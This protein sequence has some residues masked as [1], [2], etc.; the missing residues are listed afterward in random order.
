MAT[1]DGEEGRLGALR[2]GTMEF[3]Q[4]GNRFT[5]SGANSDNVYN[6]ACMASKSVWKRWYQPCE[7]SPWTTN[8][9]STLLLS[10]AS[11]VMSMPKPRSAGVSCPV[12]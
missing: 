3:G 11:K 5:P 8:A 4:R 6:L 7:E 1:V 9:P 2:W 12:H 10:Y